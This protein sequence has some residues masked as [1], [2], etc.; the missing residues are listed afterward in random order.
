MSASDKGRQWATEQR[1]ER[2]NRQPD[3]AID[4]TIGAEEVGDADACES[5][6]PDDE[7]KAD[8]PLGP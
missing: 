3:D 8:E 7:T 6:D 4:P 2:Q 5:R 1:A